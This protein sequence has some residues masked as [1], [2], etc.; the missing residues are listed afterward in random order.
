[1]AGTQHTPAAFPA[2]DSAGQQK[3][4][5]VDFR[6]ALRAL[7][8]ALDGWARE[9]VLPPASATPRLD[10][11]TLVPANR[12]GF[13]AVP[14]VQSPRDLSAGVRVTNRLIGKGGGAGVPL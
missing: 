1:F 12:V 5:P 6:W 11:H 13:P 2:P 14:G 3:A 9:G 4:N 10:R 8:V 7:L